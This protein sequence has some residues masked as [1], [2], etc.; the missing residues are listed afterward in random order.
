MASPSL[1]GFIARMSIALLLSLVGAMALHHG[2]ELPGQRLLTRRRRRAP[3]V[4]LPYPEEPRRAELAR[5]SG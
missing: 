4:A 5:A 3:V 2:V 1:G